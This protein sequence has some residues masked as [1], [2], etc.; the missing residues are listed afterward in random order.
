MLMSLADLLKAISEEILS[1]PIEL[2]VETCELDV[3]K[4]RMLA[5]DVL[6]GLE[7]PVA[8]VSAMDGYALCSDDEAFPAG[9]SFTVVGTAL[10]GQPFVG[11][12]LNGQCVRIMTGAVV[13]ASAHTVVMQEQVVREAEAITLNHSI[14]SKQNIRYQGEELRV[15]ECVLSAGECLSA[16]DILLLAAIGCAEVKVYRRLKVGVM[17]SG[18]E[19]LTLGERLTQAGQLYDANRPLLKALLSSPAI[20]V[21]DY[22]LQADEVE[23]LS[24]V[25]SEAAAVCDVVIT[26]GGVSVGDCDYL[27]EAVQ[28]IGNIQYYRVNMKP[29]K[30]FVYGRIGQARYVGLPGNP[31][32]SFVGFQQIVAPALALLAGATTAPPVLMVSAQLS[33]DIG[34]RHGRM[35][36]QRGLMTFADGRW[37]VQAQ[38]KQDS[39]RVYALSRANCLIALEAEDGDKCA[40]EWVQVL[41]FVSRFGGGV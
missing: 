5:E 34:K 8:D 21:M 12:L 28:A 14:K 7:L 9:A 23:Q 1:N 30:P 11:E 6:A 37:Q 32:S 3:A 41:P 20:E 25:L 38:G 22:G 26:S 35:D 4:G 39:H 33:A 40:G 29:G 36:F 17:S 13:P 2:A 19:L 18:D 15:G 16:A 10:A 27:K 31:V 24:A